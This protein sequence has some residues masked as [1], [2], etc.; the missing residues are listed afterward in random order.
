MQLSTEQPGPTGSRAPPGRLDMI[1][2]LVQ[3]FTNQRSEAGE[4]PTEPSHQGWI[5]VDLDGTLAHY[6]GW[7]GPAH[8]GEPIAPMLERVRQWLAD[9]FEV[10][11]FTARASVPEY[12][13]FVEIWLEQNGLPPLQVTNVKDFQMLSLWDDRC[14]EVVTNRGEPR[15]PR[16]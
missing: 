15:V 10:R 6:D 3:K 12:V 8:I 9:G 4:I 13:P 14:V 5:G 11:I 16:S 1:R 2:K 7:Y